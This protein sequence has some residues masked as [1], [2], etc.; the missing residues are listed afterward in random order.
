MEGIISIIVVASCFYGF[1]YSSEE[2]IYALLDEF[3][4]SREQA[5]KCIKAACVG[6]LKQYTK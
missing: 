2:K 5:D 6:A 1:I 4:F 3:G